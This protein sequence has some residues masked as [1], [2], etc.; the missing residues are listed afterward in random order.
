MSYSIDDAI[1]EFGLDRSEIDARKQEMYQ[2]IEAYRLAEIRKRQD[3]TQAQ[4][5]EKMGVT[6]K[7][8]SQL[9]HGD[10]EGLR[11]GTIGRY[12]AGLGGRLRLVIDLPNEDSIALEA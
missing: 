12:A 11:V 5:A 3:M 4:L 6:Q 7:R 10:I 1:Q 8:V 2:C 9:E